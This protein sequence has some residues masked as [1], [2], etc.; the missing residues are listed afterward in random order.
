M[1]REEAGKNLSALVDTFTEND[2]LKKQ[3]LASVAGGI[4]RYAKAPDLTNKE[5]SRRARKLADEAHR[6]VA[7]LK[8]SEPFW[9]HMA[10]FWGFSGTVTKGLGTIEETTYSSPNS[11]LPRFADILM[12]A[13]AVELAAA[14][15]AKETHSKVRA[16]NEFDRNLGV[17]LAFA[18]RMLTGEKP[19]FSEVGSDDA[20]RSRFGK[21]VRLAL[22]SSPE[23]DSPRVKHLLKSPNSF[24][25]RATQAFEQISSLDKPSET[26]S[27]KLRRKNSKVAH[28][29][30]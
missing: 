9:R 27:V 24:I 22:L 30:T 12:H 20:P 21:F 8:R 25:R 13:E 16:P 5:A 14:M 3:Q 10:H 15:M 19:G 2:R 26:L 28:S 18:F 7:A 6:F 11:W 4:V 17:A 23:S 1:T 29:T